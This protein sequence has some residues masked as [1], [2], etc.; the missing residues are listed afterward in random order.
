MVQQPNLPTSMP[1][2]VVPT[3]TS[4]PPTLQELGQVDRFMY[5]LVIANGSVT[6]TELG[7][8]RVYSNSLVTTHANASVLAGTNTNTTGTPEWFIQAFS[9]GGIDDLAI[10]NAI[11]TAC[12]P[13][14]A[15]D[16]AINNGINNACA[17][18]GAINQ[19]INNGINNACAQNGTIYSLFDVSFQTSM[20]RSHNGNSSRDNDLFREFPNLNGD[21]PSDR[22]VTFP[23]NLS[24][25]RNFTRA[26]CN[27]LLRHYNQLPANSVQQARQ[28]VRVFIGAGPL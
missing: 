5:K 24:T 1:T 12:A 13:N 15:I 2:D 20:A 8:W 21:L 22:N 11:I 18:N 28:M 17:P 3:Q 7:E 6:D 4:N 25:L 19:A 16:Q 10:K 14:G 26:Q 23:Q 9:N 27:S